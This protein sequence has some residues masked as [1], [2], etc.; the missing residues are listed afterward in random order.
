MDGGDHGSDSPGK[1]LPTIVAE[2][3]FL[4]RS[5][6]H[7][8]DDLVTPDMK[9]R[10]FLAQFAWQ[11]WARTGLLFATWTLAA[12]GVVAALAVCVS[13]AGF[14]AAAHITPQ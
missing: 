13:A 2:L 7:S 3:R 10:T 1:A 5:L 12:E 9:I 6:Q 8:P 11:Q 4:G 14:H